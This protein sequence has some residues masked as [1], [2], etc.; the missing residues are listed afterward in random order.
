VFWS[1]VSRAVRTPSRLDR[2]AEV[3]FATLPGSPQTGGLAQRLFI[4]GSPDNGSQ[5]VIAWEA[6]YRSQPARR[7]SVDVALFRND[8]Q[9]L[10]SLAFGQPA[11]AMEN[12]PYLSVPLTFGSALRGTTWGAEALA[13]FEV[14]A[15]WRLVGIYNRLDGLL[16]VRPGAPPSTTTA[17][18][19]FQPRHSG[20]LRSQLDLP[21]RLEFDA[22]WY[23]VGAMKTLSNTPSPFLY[24]NPSR[25]SRLDLRLAWPVRKDLELSL[26]MNNALDPR[27]PEFVPEAF[28]RA[29]QVRRG[30]D[31]RLEWL[32]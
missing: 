21:G 13:Q 6:G 4:Q 29:A 3:W 22:G 2:E 11:I 18:T 1:A 14:N 27:H 19:G 10:R 20:S 9:R 25:W 32:F 28:N 24:V 8:Y 23:A 17:E 15:R 16:S 26:R 12:P 5:P 7:V 30:V 31:V